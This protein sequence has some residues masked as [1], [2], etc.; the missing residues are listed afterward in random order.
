MAT[1]GFNAG[2]K[3]TVFGD[4]S[5]NS[6]AVVEIYPGDKAKDRVATVNHRD[7]PK[8]D[9][10]NVPS[11]GNE[12]F[13]RPAQRPSAFGS[14]Q[15]LGAPQSTNPIF[16]T[17]LN[18]PARAET[19]PDPVSKPAISKKPTVV[20][21]DQ[22]NIVHLGSNLDLPGP[23]HHDHH[24]AAMADPPVNNPRHHKS[25]PQLKS[26]QPAL[27]RT[28]S[29]L[30]GRLSEPAGVDN[31][32][33]EAPF[34]DALEDLSHLTKADQA[35][36]AGESH[37]VTSEASKPAE[38]HPVAFTFLPPSKPTAV[39]KPLPAGPPPADNAS[40]MPPSVPPHQSQPAAAAISTLAS[41]HTQ[42]SVPEP[43]EFWDEDEDDF[44]DEHGFTTAHSYRSH[45]DNTT[46]GATTI[47]APKVTAKVRKELE[48]AKAYV[49]SL[50][51]E[52]EVEEEAWD[53]SMVAEYGE[54]IF[55]YMRN[56]EVKFFSFL[57][58]LPHFFPRPVYTFLRSLCYVLLPWKQKPIL[59]LRFFV[60]LFFPSTTLPPPSLLSRDNLP[61]I[62][63]SRHTP[64]QYPT[65]RFHSLLLDTF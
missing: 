24:R 13:L 3:R 61:I 46:C 57:F 64:S 25:Q 1:N 48:M 19:K 21:N 18:P 36:R 42:A 4:L 27:R 39:T 53:V 6:R 29:R 59:C 28:Q 32:C 60:L 10:E 30:I 45:G 26:E 15:L 22:K 31:D 41:A 14:K 5:N 58:S 40:A 51:T 47:L 8:I 44:D 38:S 9:K 12:A 11:F 2:A 37:P 50:Q 55:E 63:M 20:F 17:A 49:E 52:D 16:P 62:F 56:L 43:E 7:L 35:P 34:E 23:T 65:Q 54:E 33:A